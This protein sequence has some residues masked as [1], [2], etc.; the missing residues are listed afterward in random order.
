MVSM[1]ITEN[2]QMAASDQIKDEL[3]ELIAKQ[4][5]F[6]LAEGARFH[7]YSSKGQRVKDKHWFCRLSQN[8]RELLYGDWNDLTRSPNPD[9]LPNKVNITDIK[10]LLIGRDCPIARDGHMKKTSIDLAFTLIYEIDHE[11]YLNFVA[12]DHKTFC[13]WIDGL[14][15]LL[16]SDMTSEE[17][18]KD[19]GIL[20]EIELKIKAMD[21]L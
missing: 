21:N 16:K 19:M 6:R 2:H 18:N 14:N 13:Y 12:L 15:Y 3:I 10:G 7:K 8:Q 11:E 20:M 4:R 17:F 1:T 9:E 5:L